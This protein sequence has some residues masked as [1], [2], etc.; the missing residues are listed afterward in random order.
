[1]LRHRNNFPGG[2]RVPE[3]MVQQLQVAVHSLGVEE[4]HQQWDARREH[5]I[6]DVVLVPDRVQCDGRDHHDDKVPQPVVR[7][8][9]GRH[10]HTQSNGS[11]FRTVEEI[12][13][14]EADRVE[15]IEEEDEDDGGDGRALVICA[16]AVGDGQRNH[17]N[18]HASAADHEDDSTAEPVD[19][20]EGDE[21]ADEFPC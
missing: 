20:E 7:R 17:A 9:D 15:E 11:H 5:G 8:R 21:A 16:A 13:A 12:T 4:V 6:H 19:G 18:R 1:M 2:R 10:C 14:E 3:N